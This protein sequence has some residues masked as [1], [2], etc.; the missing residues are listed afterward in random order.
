MVTAFNTTPL[1]ALGGQWFAG[2]KHMA[3]MRW[4][5]LMGGTIMQKKIWDQISPEIQTLIINASKKAEIE[6]TNE[7]R[8]LDDKA[9]EVMEEY[10]LVSHDVSEDELDEWRELVKT[11]Y[12]YVRGDIVPE[13]A[14]DKAIKLRNEFRSQ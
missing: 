7:I 8:E 11:V 14:F 13:K 3:N 5:P 2:A 4:A 10:G 9:I 12:P 1:L 6:L